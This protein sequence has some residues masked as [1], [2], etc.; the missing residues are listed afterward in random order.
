MDKNRI[1][2]NNLS[3][4]WKKE[5]IRNLLNNEKYAGKNLSKVDVLYFAEESDII[6][7]DIVNLKRVHLLKDV[8]NNLRPLNFFNHIED[9][10][11]EPSEY[12]YEILDYDI[13]R[14]PKHLRNK[15]RYLE[16]RNI[17]LGYDLTV[18]D[19][20]VN[21]ENLTFSNCQLHSL[22]GIQKLSKLKR[23]NL[24]H[25]PFSDL[26]PLQNLPIQKLDISFSQVTD[27]SPLIDHASL[28]WI[29]VDDLDIDIPNNC[30]FI[31]LHQL[32]LIVSTESNQVLFPKANLKENNP[33]DENRIWWE[34]LRLKWQ[35]MLIYSLLDSECYKDFGITIIDMYDLLKHSNKHL[36]AIVN[37][38][39]GHI[40]KKLLDDLSPLDHLTNLKDLEIGFDENDKQYAADIL[41]MLPQHI[42]SKVKTINLKGMHV[43]NDFTPF[44][45]YINLEKLYIEECG[46]TSL[47]GIEKLKRLKHLGG[48][49]GNCFTDLSPLTSLKLEV[50][51]LQGTNIQ[52]LSI[53]EEIP[54]LELLN[55]KSLIGVF[56]YSSLFKIP[57]LNLAISYEPIQLT[58]KK[59]RGHLQ[60]EI[61]LE[62][63]NLETI[64]DLA[65]SEIPQKLLCHL[66][67]HKN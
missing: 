56:E 26:T 34:N 24:S 2:W 49:T 48:G 6:V 58:P 45:N 19:D 29:N 15:V 44:E 60:C 31:N 27:T 22:E 4:K 42:R 62:T 23:V 52:D 40:S 30:N 25:N 35:K 46:F 3:D 39:K 51:D 1:W 32:E 13:N 63:Q 18:L 64:I 16:I 50:L 8:S 59:L 38:E 17:C 11:I 54:T 21:L 20:F 55:L 61:S 12:E 5:L 41:K 66:S 37:L 33:L 53:I 7:E 10:Q 36:S 57:F 47:N 14:Y 9:F 28:E 43:A 65:P 67:M